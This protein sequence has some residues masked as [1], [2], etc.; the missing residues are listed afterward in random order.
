MGNTVL[1]SAP[2]LLRILVA[3]IE[4]LIRLEFVDTANGAPELLRFPAIFNGPAFAIFVIAVTPWGLQRGGQLAHWQ[5]G[6]RFAEALF[7]P[8]KDMAAT[9]APW[10]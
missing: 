6:S 1:M 8:S 5:R 2:E 10:R 3:P 4:A 7:V 9:V